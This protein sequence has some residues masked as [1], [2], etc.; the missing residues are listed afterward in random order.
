M[1]IEYE[2]TCLK[3]HLDVLQQLPKKQI[4][5]VVDVKEDP[6]DEAAEQEQIEQA[7]AEME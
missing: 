3:D 7:T 1:F 5:R 6:E 2:Q 4:K